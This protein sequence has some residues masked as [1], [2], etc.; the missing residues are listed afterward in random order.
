MDAES[1]GGAHCRCRVVRL[2]GVAPRVFSREGAQHHHTRELV[3]DL[4]LNVGRPAVGQ[5]LPVLEPRQRKGQVALIHAT[6]H[7]SSHAF[8]QTLLERKRFNARGNCKRGR[9]NNKVKNGL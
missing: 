4:H 8:R 6:N 5:G 3:Y 7:T 1:G 9:Q 2:A